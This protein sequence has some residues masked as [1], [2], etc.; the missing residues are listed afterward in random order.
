GFAEFYQ[1]KQ[2]QNTDVNNSKSVFNRELIALEKIESGNVESTL[3]IYPN[4][5]NNIINI[6]SSADVIENVTI[7]DINGREIKNVTLGVSEGQINISDLSHG[8]YILNAVCNGISV[9]KTF[10]NK[11]L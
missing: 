10:I 6:Y 2:N 9:S 4:P 5:T 11:K 3:F 1:Y 7:T 8:V